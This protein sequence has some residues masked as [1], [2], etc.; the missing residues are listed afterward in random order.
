[1]KQTYYLFYLWPQL[2]FETANI[3][4]YIFFFPLRILEKCNGKSNYYL[5]QSWLSPFHRRSSICHIWTQQFYP[6]HFQT[7]WIRQDSKHCLYSISRKFLDT[8]SPLQGILQSNH[9]RPGASGK[10]QLN[11]A[12]RRVLLELHLT[13]AVLIH[14]EKKIK[15]TFKGI[16]YKHLL[17]FQLVLEHCSIC[18][19]NTN[20]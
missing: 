14:V 2:V 15:Q 6:T 4:I 5:P 10:T 13:V 9:P 16:S 8:R 7:G 3:C 11:S 18:R 1:M 12:V 19:K 17:S 20:T